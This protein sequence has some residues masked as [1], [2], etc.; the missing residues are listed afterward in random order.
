MEGRAIARPN[1]D[2]DSEFHSPHVGHGFNGGPGNCPAEQ[3]HKRGTLRCCILLQ[4]R[5]GQLPGRT[6]VEGV[7]LPVAPTLQW[8]AGQLPGRT[9]ASTVDSATGRVYGFN[10]GPG[11]CPAEPRLRESELSRLLATLKL[12]W[13]AGQLPGRTTRG[14]HGARLVLVASMEGRAIARPNCRHLWTVRRRVAG[15][16]GGPGNC[17]AEPARL[18]WGC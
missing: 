14:G 5:A 11:N 15:F 2:S 18:I 13:R 8:R 17:P 9:C 7:P 3:S 10:G 16:N 6:S 4:W 12:Q 1:P